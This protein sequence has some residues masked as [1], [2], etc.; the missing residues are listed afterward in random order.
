VNR[1][2]LTVAILCSLLL[3]FGCGG[4]FHG[5]PAAEAAIQRFHQAY[6]EGR[7]DDN[8]NEADARFR[9]ATTRQKYDL[10]MGALQKK[11]GKVTSTSNVQWKVSTENLKTSVVMVQKT[12]FESGEGTET[13]TFAIDGKQAT[14]IGYFVQS[15]DLVTK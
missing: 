5:K 15:M 6:N 3:A 1:A 4:V 11:L 8:W 10:F 13:F 14:L 9:N 2:R 12:V 7:I